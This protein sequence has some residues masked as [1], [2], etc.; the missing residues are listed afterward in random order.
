MAP[1]TTKSKITRKV[2]NAILFSKTSFAMEKKLKSF[3]TFNFLFF[4]VLVSVFCAVDFKAIK[5]QTPKITKKSK[6]LELEYALKKPIP[7]MRYHKSKGEIKA[8]ANKAINIPAKSQIG[9]IFFIW[10]N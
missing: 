2:R 9:L 5:T 6:T 8:R 4:F 3:E 1:K 7:I 10:T